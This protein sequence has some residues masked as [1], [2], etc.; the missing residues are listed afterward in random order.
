MISLT[1]TEWLSGSCQFCVASHQFDCRVDVNNLVTA[2]Q[3]F[4]I[5]P[6]LSFQ[7]MQ[8]CVLANLYLEYCETVNSSVTRI[9]GKTIGRNG[10][11]VRYSN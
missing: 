4:R 3:M 6:L 11:V 1:C 2:V 10:F 9:P 8:L 7:K 5:K